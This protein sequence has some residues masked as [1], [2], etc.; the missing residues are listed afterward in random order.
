MCTT[1]ALTPSTRWRSRVRW[2]QPTCAVR[3]AGPVAHGVP[4]RARSGDH[5]YAGYSTLGDGAVLDLRALRSIATD[6]GTGT[7][8]VGAG[9]S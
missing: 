3:C 1:R 6:P 2:M 9:D 8:S 4:L 7:T 5:S